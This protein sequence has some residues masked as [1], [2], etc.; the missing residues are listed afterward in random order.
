MKK[1]Y[2]YHIPTFVHKDGRIGKIGCTEEEDAKIR[3]QNQG[4]TEYEILETHT[5]IMIASNREIELQKEYGYKVDNKP[6]YK[7]VK[8]A[9]KESRKKGGMKN[10]ESGQ[11]KSIRSLGGKASVQILREKGHY[12]KMGKLKRKKVLVYKKDGTFVG[13]YNSGHECALHLKLDTSKISM[14]CNGQR[15]TT[16]GY[17]INFKL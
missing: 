12:S 7:T 6:Y 16:G 8:I 13:E 4:Y 1:Y 15:K 3:V 14:V 11:L 17:V 10:V 5:D 2:I 9:T